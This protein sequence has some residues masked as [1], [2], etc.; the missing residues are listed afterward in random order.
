M[1]ITESE[2]RGACSKKRSSVTVLTRNLKADENRLGS[3]L[4]ARFARVVFC[5]FYILFA[6]CKNLFFNFLRSFDLSQHDRPHS[7]FPCSTGQRMCLPVCAWYWQNFATSCPTPWACF[8]LAPP[9]LC[10][11]ATDSNKFNKSA[12]AFNFI[13]ISQTYAYTHLPLP[14]RRNATP[15]QTFHIIC[16][17]D[18]KGFL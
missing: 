7:L 14:Q 4:A 12:S 13:K 18:K 5:S 6:A 9:I 2:Q 10:S 3:D 16:S 1:A 8:P 15:E 17:N 11:C